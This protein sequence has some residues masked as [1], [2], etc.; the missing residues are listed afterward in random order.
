MAEKTLPKPQTDLPLPKEELPK[1]ELEIPA[2]TGKQTPTYKSKVFIGFIGISFLLAFILGGLYFGA[3]PIKND[4]DNIQVNIITE[5]PTPEINFSR[6]W[7]MYDEVN[8][9]MKYP[10]DYE[11][12]K[13]KIVA[14][15]GIIELQKDTIQLISPP[16][17]NSKGNMSIIIA[18]KPMKKT[19]ADS[20]N[21]GS[22]CAE[23]DG[24]KLNVINLGKNLFSESGLVNCGPNE[25]AFFYIINNGTVYEAKVET[26]GDYETEA[27]PLV[28]QILSTMVFND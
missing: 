7:K 26:T 5:T 4:G 23:L 25:T 1:P 11:L 15:E 22:T 28:K 8:Y 27:L 24:K 2:K 9:T 16:F 18:H 20:V 13:D 17:P 19:L 21:S 14:T 12:N 6:N 10:Q 3:K